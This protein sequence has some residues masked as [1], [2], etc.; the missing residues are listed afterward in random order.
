[1]QGSGTNL[2]G[3]ILIRVF[4]FSV[5]RD[6]SMVFNAAARLGRSPGPDDIRRAIS[7]FRSL[8]AP[9]LID[10]KLGRKFIQRSDS[11]DGIFDVL[12]P[13]AVRSG[14]EFARLIYAYRAHALGARE[15]A[16]KSDDL[17]EQIDQIDAVLPNRRIILLTRDFRDNVV[18]VGGK[19][20][21]PVEPI[22]AAQYVKRQVRLYD[23][24]Y[25]RAGADGFHV[26]FET[27]VNSPQ[28]FVQDFA[29]HFDLTPAVDPGVALQT[30]RPRANKIARW[31]GLSSRN[32]AWCEAILADELSAW[33]YARACPDAACP[34]KAEMAAA[35]VRDAVSRVPQRL[36]RLASW[37]RA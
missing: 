26:A 9:S 30:I 7:E 17:W 32:L 14:A 20:F 5:L 6:R 25:R 34:G 18:S 11:F 37:L 29:R 24:E 15:M 33:G 28:D 3:R 1:V 12:Q 13:A 23:A 8:V 10:R 21:G 31:R 4:G 36:R 27:L 16:I 22:C 2:L 19:H 35:R